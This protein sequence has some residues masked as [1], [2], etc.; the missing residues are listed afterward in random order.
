MWISRL[1]ADSEQFV[2]WAEILCERPRRGRRVEGEAG[3][4]RRPKQ[5]SIYIFRQGIYISVT[6]IKRRERGREGGRE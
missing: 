4:G 1:K 5:G 3:A 6:K 2:A